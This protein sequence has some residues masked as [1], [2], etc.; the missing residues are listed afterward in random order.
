L[1][2][3]HR[4]ALVLVFETFARLLATSLGSQLRSSVVASVKSVDQR[5]YASI[6]AGTDEP[7]WIA[8]LSLGAVGGQ[9]VIDLSMSL[10][11][12]LVERVLGG[13][14]AGPHPHRGLTELETTLISGL[15][16]SGLSDLATALAPLCAIQPQIVRVETQAELLKAA[17]QAEAYAV[18]VLSL[19]LPETGVGPQNITVALPLQGLEPA[20]EAF[21]GGARKAELEVQPA[22][23]VDHLLDAPV[24]VTLRFR[25]VS[26]RAGDLVHLEEGQI[27]GLE[28]RTSTPLALDVEGTEVL[29]AKPGRLGRRLACV[30]VDPVIDLGATS[31]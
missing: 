20:F 11:M 27:I 23:I 6:V 1:A 9:A 10:A 2:S 24:D 12:L 22:S 18:T 25:P 21:A 16:E 15:I 28:H 8:A 29:A 26:M 7:T 3:A 30:I 14:G 5:D 31:T 13:S 19:D 4:R 17:P